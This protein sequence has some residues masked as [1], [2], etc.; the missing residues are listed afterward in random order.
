MNTTLAP[1]EDAIYP[2]L[3]S[4]TLGITTYMNNTL[5]DCSVGNMMLLFTS[6]QQASSA[7]L[8]IQ[9]GPIYC[10]IDAERRINITLEQSFSGTEFLF[11]QRSSLSQWS[12]YDFMSTS[13]GALMDTVYAMNSTSEHTG[14]TIAL[15]IP[16]IGADITADDFFSASILSPGQSKN[17]VSSPDN[18]TDGSFALAQGE[19]HDLSRLLDIFAK[20]YYSAVMWDLNF[21]KS[22]AFANE[23]TVRYLT[24]TINAATGNDTMIP[25]AIL[26][27]P[28]LT[29]R[30][31]QFEIQYI[32]S[33]PRKK[34]TGSLVISVVVSNIVLLSFF[35]SLFNW[36][37]LGYLQRHDPTWNMCPGCLDR[38]SSYSARHMKAVVMKMDQDPLCQNV[39]LDQE[40]FC[41]GYPEQEWDKSEKGASISDKSSQKT[42]RP[43]SEG[44]VHAAE[45]R[46][47]SWV[48][49]S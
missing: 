30:P 21:D 3:S 20:S 18:S 35:W 37:A 1:D 4:K 41:S 27:S 25:N 40:T 12:V 36:V 43:Q 16:G 49:V 2:G 24:T 33:V 34:D 9:T 47:K 13:F 7:K 5:R 44:S 29:G 28:D 48:T 6:Q 23:H 14:T 39:D 26:G 45:D 15:N 19:P 46:M 11:S 8:Q 32:C 17:L 22:N 31:A 42:L 10:S 38:N